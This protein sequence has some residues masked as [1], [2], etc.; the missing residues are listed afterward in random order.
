MEDDEPG[1]IDDE[2]EFFYSQCCQ[3]QIFVKD[4][5]HKNITFRINQ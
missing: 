2:S 3:T 1:K 4:I 5:S